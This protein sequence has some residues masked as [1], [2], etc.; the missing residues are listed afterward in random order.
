MATNGQIPASALVA[1]SGVAG[2]RLRLGA[3]AAWE[4]LRAAVHAT[5]G[6]WP[7]PTGPTDAY[8]PLAVQESIFRAR[9]TTTYLAGRPYKVWAGVRWYQRAGTAQAAVPGTSNHGFGITVDIA[10]VGAVNQFTAPRYLQLAPIA[11]VHGWSNVEG[12]SIGEPWHWTYTGPAELTSA[13]GTS[14]GGA[15]PSVPAVTAPTPLVPEEDIMA[16]RAELQA[17]LAS[18]LTPVLAAIAAVGAPRVLRI[19]GTD[20]AYL[21]LGAARR[22]LSAA[23]YAALDPRPT[24][25]DLA[26]S[27]AFWALPLI[28]PPAQT[29]RLQGDATGAVWYVEDGG[30]RHVDAAEYAADG[31]PALRDLPATHAI[32]SLPII[33][34]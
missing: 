33:G 31:K 18:A 23:Q 32:W 30:R 1:I 3:A 34:G 10:N 26:P 22:A 17:D 21:D 11:A 28:G 16:S 25:R 29:F 5:H 14:T 24:I 9:Y 7:T 13:P 4:A 12:R 20:G 8:R 19:T 6:W 27:D 15:V 2:A